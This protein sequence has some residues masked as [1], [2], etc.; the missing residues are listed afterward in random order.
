MST[1]HHSPPFSAFA[2]AI[3]PREVAALARALPWLEAGELARILLTA[4]PTYEGSH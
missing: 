3:G 1:W 4:T 2:G